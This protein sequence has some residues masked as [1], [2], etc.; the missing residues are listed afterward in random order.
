MI[1]LQAK[2]YYI[3]LPLVCLAF[4][5][6]SSYPMYQ[7]ILFEVLIVFGYLASVT[8]ILNQR[9]E[10]RLV[11]MMYYSWAILWVIFAIL[12][13]D[14]FFPLLTQSG[15]GFLVGGGIFMF[16]YL[17]SRKGLGAGD[18]KFMSAVGLYTGPSMAFS[19]MVYG[20]ILAAVVCIVLLA[21]RKIGRKDSL[22]LAPFLY[23]AFL[24]LLFL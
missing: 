2:K 10:N 21:L 11:L 22:C 9:I 20:T 19:I 13:H 17:I 23:G 3:M 5:F 7:T 8:D 15:L 1:I 12:D 24:L 4:F 6:T 18:V 14:T 16:L